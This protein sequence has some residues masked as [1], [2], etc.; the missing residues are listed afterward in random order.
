VVA[1]ATVRGPVVVVPIYS[2][3][4]PVVTKTFVSKWKKKKKI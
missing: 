3:G 4:V 1:A 2:S